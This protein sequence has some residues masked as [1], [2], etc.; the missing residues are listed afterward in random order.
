MSRQSNTSLRFEGSLAKEAG[1][2]D[3]QAVLF[4]DCMDRF[5]GLG[6]SHNE[7]VWASCQVVIMD[8]VNLVIKKH[9]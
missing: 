9:K 7:S 4:Q 3:E 8:K 2:S 1:L 6:L 5:K